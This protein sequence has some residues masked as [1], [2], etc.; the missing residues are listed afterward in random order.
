M[1][2]IEFYALLGLPPK[3]STE[4]IKKAFKSMALKYHPDKVHT[5]NRDKFEKIKAAYDFLMNAEKKAFYDS[6]F[7]DKQLDNMFDTFFTKLIEIMKS[8]TKNKAPTST[9]Y[10]KAL[11]IKVNVT[12]EE[13][14][15]SDIKKVVVK[16]RRGEGWEKVPFYI[17]LALY[18]QGT[19]VFDKQGDEEYGAKGD[20]QFK[21]FIQEHASVKR[22]DIICNHDL[23]I[24]TAMNLYEYYYGIRRN[25]DYFNGEQLDIYVPEFPRRLNDFYTYTHKVDGKGLPYVDE[26]KNVAYG[27]LY[28]YFRLTLPDKLPFD[29]EAK[30]RLL[31]G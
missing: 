15:N 2:E 14:Y 7:D 31:F 4:D 11:V 21:L 22:D 10:V 1:D 23:Y 5:G 3:A 29:D 27:D 16:L 6:T 19:Y 8:K 17:D 18:E 24:E 30:L 20:I 12:L 28:I 13:I 25:I 26:N 9:P